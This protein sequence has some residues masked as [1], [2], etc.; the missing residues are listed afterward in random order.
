[1]YNLPSAQKKNFLLIEMEYSVI[2]YLKISRYPRI[3]KF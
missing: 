1:M 2:E 3:V